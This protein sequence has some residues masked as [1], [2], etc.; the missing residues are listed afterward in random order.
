MTTYFQ[1]KDDIKDVK[2]QQETQNRVNDLRLKILEDHVNILQQQIDELKQ[3][4][5]H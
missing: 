1:L 2:S 5:N 4:S 3:N